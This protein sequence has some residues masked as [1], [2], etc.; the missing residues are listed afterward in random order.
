MLKVQDQ[1]WYKPNHLKRN[2]SC[3][4]FDRYMHGS[5]ICVDFRYLVLLRMRRLDA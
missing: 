4:T 5:E 2:G 3:R 1:L